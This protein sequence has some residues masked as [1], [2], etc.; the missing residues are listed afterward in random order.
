MNRLITF[1]KK[2]R[3]RQFLTVFLVGL[4]LIVNTACSSKYAQGAQPYNPSVQAGG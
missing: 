4:L 2:L 3:L 1:V